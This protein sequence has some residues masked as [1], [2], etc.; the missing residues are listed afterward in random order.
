MGE[1]FQWQADEA[2]YDPMAVYGIDLLLRGMSQR[3]DDLH[4]ELEQKR[5][6]HRTGYEDKGHK[7][8]RKP[9]AKDSKRSKLFQDLLE[10]LVIGVE[11]LNA[12][13]DK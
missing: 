6:P 9:F 5:R 12:K 7:G 10:R 1:L 8:K 2:C 3:I 4:W 11:S 13:A